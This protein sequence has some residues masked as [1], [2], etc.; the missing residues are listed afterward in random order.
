MFHW[1]LK[2]YWLTVES[3]K[4]SEKYDKNEQVTYKLSSQ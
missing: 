2:Y 1:L 4:N 3:L